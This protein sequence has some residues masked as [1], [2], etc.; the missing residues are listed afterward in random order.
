VVGVYLAIYSVRIIDGRREKL[1][2]LAGWYVLPDYR[3]QSLHLQR[4]LL[5]QPGYTFTDLSPKE[6]VQKINLR[7]GFQYLN[8]EMALIPNVPWPSMPG[9]AYVSDD[10]AVIEAA[11]TGEAKQHYLD[12]APCRWARHLV[13]VQGDESCHIV[14]RM[15]ERKGMPVIWIQHAS[16]PALLRRAYWP[17]G[18][19]FLLRQRAPFTVVELRVAGGRIQ[20]SLLRKPSIHA[21][22]FRSET[23]AP[24]Q[25]DYL[26][27]E[28][29]NV[30]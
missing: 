7:L 15:S 6:V 8:H 5:A 26:Y 12:H 3:M 18:S 22:M 24:E 30:P 29:V 17:V 13:L 10:P 4:A 9:R 27:S 11:L 28:I 21:R 19:Y 14:W 20:P 25:I 23:L 16:N 1:C 2:N